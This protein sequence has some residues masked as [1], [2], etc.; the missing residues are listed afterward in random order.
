MTYRLRSLLETPSPSVNGGR[1]TL[2]AGTHYLPF[3]LDSFSA[4]NGYHIFVRGVKAGLANVTIAVETAV[5]PDQLVWAAGATTNFG[6]LQAE[7]LAAELALAIAMPTTTIYPP[8]AR[9]KIVVPA[10]CAVVFT[11]L[12]RSGGE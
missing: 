11:T 10:D 3:T 5:A 6:T 2:T 7:P 8:H 4:E 1:L 9:L 12:F